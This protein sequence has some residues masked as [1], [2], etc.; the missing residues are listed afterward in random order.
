MAAANRR[1]H[2]PCHRLRT[3]RRIGCCTPPQPSARAQR[4]G[5]NFDPARL[6]ASYLAYELTQGGSAEAMAK[7]EK[8]YDQTRAK[9]GDLAK[10]DA[11]Y[12]SDQMTE[13]IKNDLNR[14]LAGD[15]SPPQKKV[16]AGVADWW[17]SGSDD[18]TFDKNRAFCP[19]QSCI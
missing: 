12:C 5:Y 16:E 14:T 17:Q 15:F 10:G 11:D 19:N 13:K 6:R 7:I 9:V 18:K 8:G 4:C 2:Q 3:R 1:P